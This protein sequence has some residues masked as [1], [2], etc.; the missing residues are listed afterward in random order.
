MSHVFAPG[1]RIGS[2]EVE[3]LIGRGGMGEVYRARDTRLKRDVALKVLPHAVAADADRL[4]RFEREAQTLAALNHQHIAAIYGIEEIERR[5]RAGDG[6]GRAARRSPTALRTGRYLSTKRCRWRARSRKRWR[7]RTSVGIIHRD[8]KPANIALRLDGTVKVLDF[9]LAKAMDS[10]ASSSV[11]ANSPTL[12]SAEQGRGAMMT[13]AGVILG[14]AAYMAPEQA[15]G[16]SVDARADIWA[17]G[18]V[19]YE[20]LT[21]T[22]AFAGETVSDSIAAILG[23]EPAF[24]A[25]PAQVPPS[26]RRLLRRCLVKDPRERLH[27]LADARLELLDAGVAEHVATQPTIVRKSS[28]AI[29]TIVGVIAALASAGATLVWQATTRADVPT[30]LIQLA[31]PATGVNIAANG[32]LISPDGRAL[33]ALGPA[34][35]SVLHLLDG[36]ASRLLDSPALCWSPDSRSLMLQGSGG[37]LLRMNIAGGPAIDF[38]RFPGVWGRGCAWSRD[39]TVLVDNERSLF[40]LDP[41]GGNS[42]PVE[43]NDD[44][45][46]DALRV[47][48][49]FLPDGRHF[50]YWLLAANGT[51][52]VRAG[53]LDSAETR[54]IGPSD[55][56]VVYAAGML[57]FQRGT[58]ASG[59][60]VRS[61]NTRTRRRAKSHHARRRARH[62]HRLRA[63][64]RV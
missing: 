61:P 42:T 10:V 7:R 50:L 30:P 62:H 3:S 1:D 20:M 45:G 23:R 60:T 39:G 55:A 47:H 53:S 15:R 49:V 35:A 8:L 12:T 54:L 63:V 57:L 33:V 14:T 22:Q 36:S 34:D 58:D 41:A 59:T 24:A 6:A 2:Y 46:T 21:G 32:V 48:P 29:A 43:V 28:A 38:G 4:A 27:H 37:R 11:A 19:L 25:L 5:A 13:H 40:R 17:F 44:G 9:G 52:T 31:L 16:K 26:V 64:L 51:R 18:C 56:P